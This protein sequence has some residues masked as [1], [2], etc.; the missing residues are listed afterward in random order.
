[1]CL[2]GLTC[3]SQY[4][5][6]AYCTA[7]LICL[8]HPLC[9]NY[10]FIVGVIICKYV[11]CLF[12]VSAKIHRCHGYTCE[13][14]LD[15]LL[16]RFHKLSSLSECLLI[17]I[18]MDTELCTSC[19]CTNY[20]ACVSL[21][22]STNSART[23]YHQFNEPYSTSY[24][25]AGAVLNLQSLPIGDILVLTK[26]ELRSLPYGGKMCEDLDLAIND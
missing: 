22:S 6:T 3:T 20:R 19:F 16:S 12:C 1:M 5:Y 17:T 4:V 11:D 24:A 15:L 26:L 10:C 25:C 13:A 2:P 9:Y 14:I 23:I 8:I 7:Q 18:T 21:S